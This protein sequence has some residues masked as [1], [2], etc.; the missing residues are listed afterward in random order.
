MKVLKFGGTSVGTVDTIK[1]V[2]SILEN[3]LAQGERMAVIFSAMGGVTN[4][5]IEIGRMASAGQAEYLELLKAV[6]ERHFA[7]IR[8]LL[9]VKNQSTT[10]AAVK[11][12]FNELEDLLRG[13]SLI[14]ELT[15][16]T[17][18]LIMSFG[19]RLSTTIITEALKHRGIATEYCDARSL[20]RTNDHFGLAEVDFEITNRQILEYFAKTSALPCVTGFVASTADGI[21]TTL[22]RGGSDYTA[23]IFGAALDA[24]VIEIWTDV[25][26]MMTADPRKVPNAFTIPSISYAEAM[27]LSHFGAKVIYPPS[28][29]PAFAKNI[30]IKVLNTFNTA[31]EGTLVHRSAN[32]KEYAITGISSIDDVALVNI[33]GSGMIGVAGI[34]ARLFTALSDH[35]ISVILISQASSEHSICFTIDPRNA[36]RA[37]E[38]LQKAFEAEIAVGDIDSISIEKNLSIIAIVGEGMKKSTGVSGKLFSVLGKNGINVIATAQGSSEL[39]IS[40]VLSKN[41]LSK[42]L[43]AIHGVFFQ[44]ETRSLNLFIV[45]VGLIGGTL[46]EQIRNQTTYLRDEKFLKLNVAGLT[47]TKKML[48]EP[49]G[50]DPTR[51]RDELDEL[52][53]KTSLPA[54]V[55]RIIELNLPNSVFVD[56]TS[57]KDIVYYYGDLLDANISVVTPNKVANSGR[58]AE[59]LQLQRMALHRGVKFLYETN[60]GAGLPIINTIQGLMASGDKF[61]K[62]EAILSGT[63]SYIFNTFG[64]GVRFVDVVREAKAKGYTEPDPRD[65]LSGTDVARKILILA[66]EVGVPLE[67]EDIAIAQL[68]PD[69]CQQAPSIEAFF[70]ELE[71]SNDYFEKLLTDAQA[72]GEVLRYIAT[73]ENDRATVELRTVGPQHPFYT[74]S[75]SDNIVSFTTERYKDRPLVV[76]GP[77]AGAEVTAS[78]VFAD[79]MS[80]SSYLG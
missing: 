80:I 29:Q 52:G 48:L 36:D 46:L 71:A 38:V 79:I 66:R 57:D 51:W 2:I 67:P 47:N 33:Q 68:L 13:V 72:Q 32:G 64:P 60:V 56:C 78:G 23:S 34:S 7:T 30:L 70:A 27:E 11:G 8:G 14:R 65:D 42:A 63:L 22:G 31:F 53:V 18:D 20:I 1:Q 24:E 6:E 9:N 26:G 61:L 75:G 59:Y 5:L 39:N 50:I 12:L 15:P 41:D 58:Y 73:L 37:R 44:S 49:D 25:D 55:Q 62:I 3:N 10:F 4:R 74:L 69:N 17:L 54:F 76:K 28:L 21:T 45:G 77:G 35:R 16:R 43:N 40:V 19:E